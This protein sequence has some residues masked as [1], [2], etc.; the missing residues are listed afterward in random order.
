VI[1]A[2]IAVIGG[3]GSWSNNLTGT[4]IRVGTPYGPSPTLTI[5]KIGDKDVVFLPRHGTQHT[6]PP[7]RINNRAN[8][9]ALHHIGIERI[10]ATNTVGAVNPKIIPSNLVIPSDFIDFTKSQPV[11]FYDEGPVTHID[12][13]SIYCPELRTIIADSVETQGKTVWNNAVYGCT[14]GPRYESPAEIR[15]LRAS[16]CDIVGMTGVPEAILAHELEMCYATICFVSNRAA[17]MQE[18]I[19][20]EEVIQNTKLFES[21]LRKIINHSISNIPRKRS[22]TC[23]NTLE[24]SQI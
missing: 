20:T 21:S 6:I 7:H 11:T 15:M 8:I 16:G 13:T 2:R 4:K 18:K 19:S 12:V 14:E 5:A 9:F 17:G 24:G 22:C 1:T 3:T 10:F 23:A